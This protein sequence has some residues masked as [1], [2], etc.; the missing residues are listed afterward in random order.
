M[1]GAGVAQADTLGGRNIRILALH[2]ALIGGAMAARVVCAG[3]GTQNEFAV[4]VAAIAAM[5]PPGPDMRVMLRVWAQVLA[6]R[7]PRLGDLAGL[8]DL[9]R[10]LAA[11]TFVGDGAVPALSD[12]DLTR[13][14]AAWEAMDPAGYISVALHCAGCQAAKA[15]AVDPALFV[16]RDLDR[17]PLR[18]CATLI[19]SPGAMAGARRRFWRCQRR[20]AGLMWR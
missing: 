12:D 4:P 14:T 1:L 6:F 19:A 18:C 16:A 10:G 11:A 20:G 13:L 3:C 15:V 17:F 5:L 7:L 8:A 2:R 9:R